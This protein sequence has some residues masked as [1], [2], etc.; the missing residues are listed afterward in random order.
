MSK[1]RFRNRKDFRRFLCE[2]DGMPEFDVREI[3]GDDYIDTPGFYKQEARF[4]DNDV[5]YFMQQMMGKECLADL[6]DY[7]VKN[8]K[9]QVVEYE[10]DWRTIS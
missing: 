7:W 4:Y 10:S 8:V 6:E 9:D 5:M 1:T 2:I 3:M